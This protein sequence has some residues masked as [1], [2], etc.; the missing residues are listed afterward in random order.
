M[1]LERAGTREWRAHVAAALRPLTH[2]LRTPGNES[3]PFSRVRR[4]APML[5]FDE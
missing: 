2:L 1:T 5:P 3:G 4:P